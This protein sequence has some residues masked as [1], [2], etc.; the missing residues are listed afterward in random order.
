[1]IDFYG[2]LEMQKVCLKTAEESHQLHWYFAMNQ[3]EWRMAEQL[4]RERKLCFFSMTVRQSSRACSGNL[5]AHP[6]PRK[7]G[8]QKQKWR[9]CWF[10]SL[11][12]EG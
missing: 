3:G 9:Q 10:D 7:C 11:T 2:N 12:A 1:V 8:C 5:K 6:A 4:Y